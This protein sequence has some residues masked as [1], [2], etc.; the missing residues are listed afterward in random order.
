MLGWQAGS[1]HVRLCSEASAACCSKR[2][3][4]GCICPEDSRWPRQACGRRQVEQGLTTSAEAALQISDNTRHLA[5]HPRT[6][7]PH[8]LP[9]EQ[10]RRVIL[11][12]GQVYYQLSRMRRAKK[13]RDIV[14]V[15]LE[16]IAPFPYDLVTQVGLSQH[17]T[18]AIPAALPFWS[19]GAEPALRWELGRHPVRHISPP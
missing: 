8:L 2:L 5:Y 15:R 10:I 9:P 19:G 1:C 6:G 16:Q 12:S 18:G 4:H 13:I 3:L 17:C 7:E 14:L 11:C